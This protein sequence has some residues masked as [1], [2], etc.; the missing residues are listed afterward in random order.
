MHGGEKEEKGSQKSVVHHKKSVSLHK[1]KNDG[2][3]QKS[4]PKGNDAEYDQN[5]NEK[6]NTVQNGLFRIQLLGKF[7][8]DGEFFVFDGQTSQHQKGNRKE[9]RGEHDLAEFYGRNSEIGVDI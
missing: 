3:D 9:K 4:K 1:V 6:E 8:G 7:I 5:G 2:D